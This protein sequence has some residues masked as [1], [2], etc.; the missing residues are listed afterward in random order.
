LLTNA[1][2]HIEIDCKTPIFNKV[3]TIFPKI[4]VILPKNNGSARSVHT[5]N[6]RA[7]AAAPAKKPIMTSEG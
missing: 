7:P 4:F 3:L 2:Y 6:R 1:Y 5:K